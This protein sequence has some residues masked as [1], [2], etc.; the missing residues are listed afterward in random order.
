MNKSVFY[1]L[2]LLFAC[3]TFESQAQFTSADVQVSVD[4]QN[5]SMTISWTD[6][7]GTSRCKNYGVDEK[8]SYKIGSATTRVIFDNTSGGSTAGS[9]Q[10]ITNLPGEFFTNPV[11]LTF[12]G[13][14]GNSYSSCT[15]TLIPFTIPIPIFTK[16]DDPQSVNAGYD[17]SCANVLLNWDPPGLGAG[18]PVLRYEVSR[19]T[20][21]TTGVF[22]NVATNI[23]GNSTC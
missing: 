22:T 7:A 8:L 17:Q 21:N 19:R 6:V 23:S 12:E 13:R 18:S 20:A 16:V 9:P 3:S 11:N 10:T 4:Y 14:F 1:F 2:I 15:S 5:G